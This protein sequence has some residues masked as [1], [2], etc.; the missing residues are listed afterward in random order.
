[1]VWRT[2]DILVGQRFTTEVNKRLSKNGPIV[3][4]GTA[5]AA[6]S[7][8]VE[9]VLGSAQNPESA[10]PVR[11]F[12]VRMDAEANL[13]RLGFQAKAAECY[14]NF[15]FG[16]KQLLQSLGE[17]YPITD[18]TDPSNT[19]VEEIPSDVD[20]WL[21]GVSDYSAKLLSRYRDELRSDKKK[22]LPNELRG[23]D[24]LRRASL[25]SGGR[26]Y[27]PGVLLFNEFPQILIPRAF[28][29]CIAYS[30][31]NRAA[32]PDAPLEVAGSVITQIEEGMRF[33]EARVDK[34]EV[35]PPGKVTARLEFE[36]PMTAVR[37]IMA[38]AIC[39]RDY[40]DFKNGQI[41][42]F[43]NRIEILSPG[44][45]HGL[46]L[47]ED[48]EY[49][50]SDLETEPEPRNSRLANALRWIS[51]VEGRGSGIPKAIVDCEESGAPQPSVISTCGYVKVTVF[52][53]RQRDKVSLATG[54]AGLS[55]TEWLAVWGA[56]MHDFA[57][58]P[59]LEDLAKDVAKDP[60][61][62]YV[63]KCFKDVYSVIHRDPL[64]KAA[65]LA[66]KELLELIESELSR[67]DV[68]DD[69][70]PAWIDDVRR[71]IRQDCIQQTI[72]SLFLK[73][74]NQPDPG[75]FAAAWQQLEEPHKLPD[76][77][78]W[79][80][81]AKQFAKRMTEVLQSSS[82]LRETFESLAKAQ[83]SVALKELAGL[84]PEFDLETYREALVERFGSLDFASLDATGA[85]YNEVRLWSV[86]VPQSVRECHEYDPQLLEI[87]KEH[88][89]RL[90]EAG[91]LDADQQ[92]T[93]KLQDE[94][95]QA[96]VNQPPRPVLDAVG[97]PSD[98]RLVILGDPGSGKS[99]LLR[100]LALQWARTDDAN[101]RYTQALPLMIELRDYNR[102]E[103]SSGKDFLKY[104]HEARSWHRLNQ[105]TLNHLLDKPDRVVLLLDGLDEVFDPAERDL[106][107][108][109]IHRFSNDHKHVRI[110]L[111]SRVVGYKP[112]RLRDA[113]FRHFMLQDLDTEQIAGFLDN[114]HAITF[115]KPEE[116]EPKHERLAKAIENSNSIAQLAGNPLLLTM[117]AI[118]NRNQKLPDDR[119]DLYQ[120][121]S[122]LLLH[123]WDVER[124]LG[125]F[126]GLST[127]IGL[128]EKTDILRSIA[129]AMQTRLS[130]N[131]RANYID[132]KTLTSLI[133][134]YLHTELRIDQAKAISRALVEQLR[135]RNFILCYIGADSYAFVHRTFLEYFCAADIVHQFNVAKTLGEQDLIDLF[136]AHCRDD[137][138]REVLR[139]I[140]GQIDEQF[141]GRIVEQLT[142]RTDLT[143]WH[144]DTPIPEL[145]L[146]LWC[147]GEVRNSS[148]LNA[149]FNTLLIA[150]VTVFQRATGLA[151]ESLSELVTAAGNLGVMP[152][153]E[154]KLSSI[155]RVRGSAEL[156][157]PQ[158]VA[159]VSN[160]RTVVE[161]FAS[162][163]EFGLRK[164]A[165]QALAEKWPD[166]TTRELL[167]QRAVQDDHEDPR[168]AALQALAEKWPDE[169][170]RKLLQQNAFDASLTKEQRAEHCVAL[171]R[172]HSELGRILITR[173]LDGFGPYLDL[174][175]PIPRDHIEAAAQKSGVSPE[176][177]DAQVASLSEWLGW[178][179]TQGAPPTE[180]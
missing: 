179:I 38:N 126:P 33:V 149:A 94:R 175:K 140:C 90:C 89:K 142:M 60:A 67:A 13:A 166:E 31:T 40:S 91:E 118:L 76:G 85:Y 44:T 138:W 100:F 117:M 22:Q 37:E 39:H 130:D 95:R 160:D 155:E 35:I 107:V 82:Q 58:K 145:S 158:F 9:M 86:F 176:E 97:R 174:T 16:I 75:A 52:P 51:H 30:G 7:I 168:S 3:I 1:K 172:M 104:L 141:V 135:A 73:P 131:S 129:Y 80:F 41:R 147:L 32:V 69:E 167:Q 62:S 116:A 21:T 132:G 70:H 152:R 146:A 93:E 19:V 154:E 109:D 2:G 42:L 99:S 178:D 177:I 23:Q 20:N 136:D 114:W 163:P 26:L 161:Q 25:M 121:C 108:N 173:D 143:Q 96:Y 102:W 10:G 11:V 113:E 151:E 63:G 46:E 120:Q 68:P 170:T 105:H 125:E 47:T 103:C 137:D 122:R 124:T 128:R 79:P 17:Y 5:R 164:G 28:I 134:D 153:S 49:Q 54:K 27:A 55:G 101:Q 169:A 92:E 15:E 180:T 56:A 18:G 159:A 87:P 8:W 6:G 144:G 156:Y 24:F 53:R 12:P 133:E 61:K 106:V 29:E 57:F 4:C 123:Q 162:F 115:D 78:S 64:T 88:L 66:V 84:P 81:I 165:I 139:L 65:G 71:F 59:V 14:P 50:L 34:A 43:T 45:W 157:W 83:D 112:Q 150:C 98:E 148:Q 111:T 74:G 171:G 110:V 77:F 127:E 119:V 48:E 72:A 36:Y